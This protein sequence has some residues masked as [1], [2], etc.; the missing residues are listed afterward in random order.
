M[1][2]TKRVEL[3]AVPEWVHHEL[4]NWSRWCWSGAYPHPL[5][6]CRCASLEG[7]YSRFSE[8]TDAEA[9][10]KKPIPVNFANAKI[11]QGVY[12]ILPYLPQQVL[13]A[14]YPQRH[15]QKRVVHVGRD[16]YDAALSVAIFRVMVAFDGSG[17]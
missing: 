7:N 13:R 9:I 2:K 10:D 3:R 5:P 8:D 14:E 6:P 4:L 11:V 1:A 17:D 15:E 12:E 16:E